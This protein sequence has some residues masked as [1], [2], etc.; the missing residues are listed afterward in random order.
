MGSSV[1]T[2]KPSPPPSELYP[3]DDLPVGVSVEGG[4]VTLLEGL[5]VGFMEGLV[6]TVGER[7]QGRNVGM[8]D[9]FRDDLE[10]RKAVGFGE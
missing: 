1:G 8:F 6:V 5:L 7:V 3:N 9:G 10:V 4:K 2:I